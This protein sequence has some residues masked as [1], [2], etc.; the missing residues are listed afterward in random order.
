[1]DDYILEEEQ[2]IIDA[3]LYELGVLGH[4]GYCSFD[5]VIDNGYQIHKENNYWVV[6]LYRKEYDKAR[7]IVTSKNYTNV[8]NAC[9]DILEEMKADSYFFEGKNIRIPKGTRVVISKSD[10]CPKDEINIGIVVSSYLRDGERVYEVVDSDGRT[11]DGC[12]YGLKY[13]SD[14]YIRTM[15]DCIKDAKKQIAGNI[16]N[17]RQLVE[18]NDELFFRQQDVQVEIDNFIRERQIRK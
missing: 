10:D 7:E 3:F 8:Y 9:M 15:E 11:I 17:I 6:T 18:E 12:L 5:D 1:M 2:E 14:T 16:E 4:A 13:Y